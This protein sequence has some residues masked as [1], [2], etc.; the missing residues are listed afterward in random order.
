M[1]DQVV[2]RIAVRYFQQQEPPS[3]FSITLTPC[4]APEAYEVLLSETISDPSG[5]PLDR[6]LD[7]LL[8]PKG[9]PIYLGLAQALRYTHEQ[10]YPWWVN[11]HRTPRLTILPGDPITLA[12]RMPAASKFTLT[13]G[14][15]ATQLQY[16]VQDEQNATLTDFVAS[17]DTPVLLCA[18]MALEALQRSRSKP[19][20]TP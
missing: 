12:L 1:A 13:P 6:Q 18:A 20:P 14:R 4:G 16:L 8:I 9:T 2:R 5:H 3:K 15:K 11:Q 7:H 10:I 17:R 19:G